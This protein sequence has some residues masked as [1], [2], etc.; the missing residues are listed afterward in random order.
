ML[1]LSKSKNGSIADRCAAI[2]TWQVLG[3]AVENA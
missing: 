1:A 3:F 2:D